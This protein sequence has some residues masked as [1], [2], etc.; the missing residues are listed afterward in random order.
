MASKMP[1]LVRIIHTFYYNLNELKLWLVQQD[2][3][4]GYFRET[5]EL[6]AT[7]ENN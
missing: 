1:P 7:I 3:F 2:I 5:L 6:H 4:D